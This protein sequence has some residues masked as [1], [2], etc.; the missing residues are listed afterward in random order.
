MDNMSNRNGRPAPN[1]NMAMNNQAMPAPSPVKRAEKRGSKKGLLTLIGIVGLV[2]VVALAA[3]LFLVK[4]SSTAGVIDGDKYQAVFFTNGQVYFGKLK[5]LNPDY[6][7]LT[8][9]Y[10]LQAKSDSNK[11]GNPQKATAEDASNV[12]LVKLGSEIHGPDDEMVVNKDQI[13]FFENLKKNSN[14]STTIANY[15]AQQKN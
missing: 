15:Q 7:V 4:P 5:S 9:I 2:I 14:V 10:Y 1:R 3:W 11:E 8:D 13:L 12:Q 6:M